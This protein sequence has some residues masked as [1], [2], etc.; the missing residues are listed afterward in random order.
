MNRDISTA[1]A[2]PPALLDT[3]PSPPPALGASSPL[4]GSPC[5]RA[6]HRAALAQ[7]CRA[8]GRPGRGQTAGGVGELLVP[9][10]RDPQGT[11]RHPP[12]PRVLKVWWLRRP[13][14]RSTVAG[15]EYWLGRG[16]C[17][18]VVPI[19]SSGARNKLEVLKNSSSN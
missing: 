10:G 9:L 17:Q 19:F 3:T 11:P 4:I 12:S 7:L 18:V 16:D 13:K 8:R 6:A 5:C 1:A 14:C 2:E 15:G